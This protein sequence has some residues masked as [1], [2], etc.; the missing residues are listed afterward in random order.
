MTWWFMNS[1]V[2]PAEWRWVAAGALVVMLLSSLPVISGNLAQTEEVRFSGAVYDR[3]DYAVH[4]ATMHLG[5]SGNW[6][7]Q[8]EFTNEQ[9]PARFLKLAYLLL[10]KVASGLGLRFSLAYEIARILAGLGLIFGLYALAASLT[11][12]V[13]LRAMA[14]SLAVFASGMGW[15]QLMLNWLPRVDISPIDFWLIDAFAFFGM[16]TLPHF[17]LAILLTLVMLMAG[18]AFLSEREIRAP[19]VV[20]VCGLLI[21]AIEPTMVVIADLAV[22]GLVIGFWRKAQ[23]PTLGSL[24]RLL[25]AGLTQAPLL[26]YNYWALS[27]HPVWEV[28]TAQFIH[29]SPPAIYYLAG[30]ALLLPF[31]LW[32]AWLSWREKNPVGIMFAFWALCASALVYA[33]VAFQRRF[34]MGL[35]IPLGMLAAYGFWFGFVA[36]LRGRRKTGKAPLWRFAYQRRWALAGIWMLFSSLS[37]LYLVFGGAMLASLRPAALFDPREVIEGVDWLGDHAGAQDSVFSAER[38]GL[39]IPARTGLRVFLG[40]PIETVDY[41]QK[42]QIVG[43]FYSATGMSDEDRAL[44]LSRSGCRWL[45][46]GPYERVI[47]G[48]ELQEIPGIEIAYQNPSVKVYRVAR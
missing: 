23:R 22:L 46:V 43:D 31:A 30:F 3:Q 44:I 24:G 39:V 35:S 34:A 25:L 14:V 32:G 20:G 37:S 27:S 45:F 13:R 21:V 17:S 11:E 19:I 18:E 12:D 7:Y 40:H 2:S 16:M 36:W 8:L 9:H 38:T 29:Q 42:M 26:A 1:R 15:L 28:F 48:S 41:D 33:P 47:G 10:G 6:G 5:A 4:L